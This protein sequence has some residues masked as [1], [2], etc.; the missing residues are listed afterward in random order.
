MSLSINSKILALD[1]FWYDRYLYGKVNRQGDIIIMREDFLK[2]L[3]TNS[4]SL[5][6]SVIILRL[7]FIGGILVFDILLK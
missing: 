2:T 5:I 6:F 3:P 7:K 4:L 1:E